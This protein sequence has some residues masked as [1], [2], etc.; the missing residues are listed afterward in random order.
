MDRLPF[1]SFPIPIARAKS[2]R[3]NAEMAIKAY[4][5]AA[6]SD[7]YEDGYEKVAGVIRAFNRGKILLEYLE[8]MLHLRQS[9][10]F[11]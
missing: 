11:A 1:E 9:T 8:P 4:L 7:V 10:P 6:D 2:Y 3:T 5:A